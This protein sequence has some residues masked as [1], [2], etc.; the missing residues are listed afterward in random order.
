MKRTI[1]PTGKLRIE[2]EHVSATY[3]PNSGFRKIDVEWDLTSFSF[4]VTSE[5]VVEIATLGNTERFVAP[6]LTSESGNASF[7]VPESSVQ[8]STSVRLSVVEPAGRRMILGATSSISLTP[9]SGGRSQL[10]LL[11]I[12][13]LA[14]LERAFA[15]DFTTGYPVLQVSNQDG[16]YLGLIANPVFLPSILPSVVESIAYNLMVNSDPIDAQKLAAWDRQFKS[17]G[18][19]LEA[20]ERVRGEIDSVEDIADALAQA[21]ELAET[22]AAHFSKKFT[23]NKRLKDATEGED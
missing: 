20:M 9:E 11:P 7:D 23:L 22:A 14:S 16:L 12:Q 8:H 10:A 17:W 21:Q 15:V 13:P 2:L 19:D 1:N 4:D 18:C 3:D 6:L 5:V